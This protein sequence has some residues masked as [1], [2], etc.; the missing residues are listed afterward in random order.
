MS[1]IDTDEAAHFLEDLRNGGSSNASDDERIALLNDDDTESD[2]EEGADVEAEEEAEEEEEEDTGEI[3]EP[4]EDED[5]WVYPS[6]KKHQAS[7]V[8][9]M[10]FT[11][12]QH[13]D[14]DHRFSKADLL[15]LKPMHIRRWLNQLA[16]QTPT[17]GAD[18]KPLYYRSGSLKKAKGSISYFHPNKHVPWMEGHGGNPTQ[19]RSISELV[20]KVK[21]YETRGQGKKANDKRPYTREEFRKKVEIFR[22]HDNWNH[23]SKYVMM[24]LW[25]KHLILRVDD[26]CHF[27]MDAPH[28][29]REFPYALF[30]RTKWSKNVTTFRNCPDQIL[31]GSKRWQ[32]C[33][34]LHLAY[35]LE[36]WIGRNQPNV[37]FMFTES[38]DEEKA[39]ANAKQTY[40]KR[41]DVVVWRSHAF[42]DMYD[43]VGDADDRKSVGTHS[44][45]KY[46]ATEAAQQG[47]AH[48]QVEYRGRWVGSRGGSVC[49]TRYI[50]SDNPYD[51][52][53]VASLLCED[54]AVAYELKTGTEVEDEWLF[55]NLVPNIRDRYQ[56]D[57]RL[58]RVLALALLWASFNVEARVGLRLGTT[59]RA[60]FLERPGADSDPPADFNPVQKVPLHIINS[61]GRLK[62]LKVSQ[63]GG[64]AAAGDADTNNADTNNTAITTPNAAT[65]ISPS[66]TP[67]QANI[68]HIMLMM[69]NLERSVNEK[70]ELLNLS[71]ERNRAFTAQQFVTVNNNIRRYGGTIT[72]AFA[73][74]MRRQ[75]A[76]G[77]STQIAPVDLFGAYGPMDRRATLHPRPR[78]LYQLWQEW[79]TGIDG[80][81][82]A[83]DFTSSERN[84]KTSGIKQKFYRRLLVWKTQARLIDG[85]M[86]LIAAN[87]RIVSITGASTITGIIGKLIR[88]KTVY[89]DDGGIHPQLKNG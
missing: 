63:G 80:R 67:G 28:G 15:S 82:A 29:S 73:N 59:V 23:H 56:N 75:P 26:A 19:H 36:G 77:A 7:L 62:I 65:A 25:C 37:K 32:D 86:S 87:T 81:K 55:T 18:D 60:R 38:A 13:Y 89:K 21:K 85:G 79:T 6:N 50:D 31:L 72:S 57:V 1:D 53:F 48:P 24:T 34:L 33:V 47:A 10:R 16:Y 49:S 17:P 69:N 8:K 70:Y 66:Q 61:N 42:R 3:E 51:D 39:P 54:G 40:A 52:A 46:A 76:S 22:S 44:T 14:K 74:Q 12:N 45:R 43:Q 30:T 2:D 35:Y 11:K 83:K 4:D 84:N 64:T 71:I 9:F 5:D 88:F 68:H 20:L 41:C 27:K 78:D 58:C